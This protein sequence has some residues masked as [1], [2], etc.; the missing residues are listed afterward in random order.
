MEYLTQEEL[1][2]VIAKGLAVLFLEQPQF[3]IDYLAQWLLKYSKNLKLQSVRQEKSK[4][5]KAIIEDYQSKVEQKLELEEKIKEHQ[6]KLEE[7]HNKFVQSIKS[8]LYHDEFT[9]DVFIQ[10]LAEK[11]NRNVYVCELEFPTKDF[12][13]DEDDEENAH[14][15]IE[16]AKL[17]TYI[18]AS[19]GQEFLIKQSLA[20]ETGVTYEALKEPVP[21]DDGEVIPNKGIYIPNVVKEPRIVFYKWP[22]LGA[23]YALSIT[24]NTVILET[25]FDQ[26]IEAL[27][28]YN[29]AKEIQ[30]A[31][32]AQKEAEFEERAE[33]DDPQIIEQERQNYLAGL[34]KLNEPV[35]QTQKKELVLCMDTL[36]Q[37]R[38]IPQNEREEIFNLAGILTKSWELAEIAA[39][40]SDIDRQIKYQESFG[41][42]VKE[43]LETLQMEDDQYVEANSEKFAEFKELNEKK[44]LYEI[45]CLK[46]DRIR[47]RLQDREFSLQ[48]L[49][50][51]EYRLIKFPSIIQS[52]LY[53]L[54]FPKE[55]INIPNTNK[56]NWRKVQQMWNEELLSQ[57]T[58]YSHR[59]QK[60]RP[61]YKWCM[62]DRVQKRVEKIELEQVDQYNIPYG[63]LLRFLI[64]NCKLRKQD[65]EL[66][67]ENIA[68]TRAAI[69]T[70][71]TEIKRIEELKEQQ[72]KEAKE[73]V[74]NYYFIKSQPLKNQKNLI[75]K[76]GKKT[77]ANQIHYLTF[78]NIHKMKL[79]KIMNFNNNDIQQLIPLLVSFNYTI[80]NH[81]PYYLIFQYNHAEFLGNIVPTNQ[82][83]QMDIN[84]DEQIKQQ[85]RTKS[86]A[87]LH[88]TRQQLINGNGAPIFYNQ[89]QQQIEQELMQRGLGFTIAV[90]E[91]IKL[92]YTE[93]EISLLDMQF[94]FIQ[95]D[96]FLN[97]SFQDIGFFTFD[98]RGR[99]LLNP[100]TNMV[101]VYTNGLYLNED[102]NKND[103]L[104]ESVFQ[105]IQS[106][107]KKITFTKDASFIL[108]NFGQ[109]PTCYLLQ[110]KR[111][112][113]ITLHS[114]SKPK[115]N[116]NKLKLWENFLNK[117][118]FSSELHVSLNDVERLEQQVAGLSRD[119]NNIM[120][121][122]LSNDNIQESQ[123][124][125]Q[126]LLRQSSQ[127]LF[128]GRSMISHPQETMKGYQLSMGQLSENSFFQDAPLINMI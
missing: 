100:T 65:I 94:T 34:E 71:K 80:I 108:I 126:K 64:M 44:Y 75:Q 86:I 67:R 85:I 43:I 128:T 32:K 83:L 98:D 12:N 113:S 47:E 45:E 52:A 82:S 26:G 61:P 77:L 117:N 36:G 124:H 69:E 18:Y 101:G 60:T 31:E 53:L 70:A 15:N 115:G 23:F 41:Q 14:Q 40:Q 88:L 55:D 79:M 66:R 91:D 97:R 119:F 9:R 25:S 111:I 30:D 38:E 4:Q 125:Y 102:F 107:Q 127:K 96:A 2:G 16:G 21:N 22:K 121:M 29:K 118:S 46:L 1:G 106:K 6:L 50:L 17:L 35:F 92:Y 103:H 120:Q 19:K 8:S 95:N 116:S 56:L 72:L 3:P 58:S 93:I 13:I 42:P 10:Y 73:A 81:L 104:L 84:L 5:K 68:Q 59:G 99:V 11:Y 78:Q 28:A 105:Y 109:V 112:N 89:S 20:N 63:R 74:L 54:G 49:A 48:L 33:N 51:A 76:N 7:N 24:Y 57:I 123:G 87:Q 27:I 114:V 39:L 122:L 110:T 62:V 90:N 37:D